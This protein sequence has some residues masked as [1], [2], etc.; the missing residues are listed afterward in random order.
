LMKGYPCWGSP[1][2]CSACFSFQLNL[3]DT[4]PA[5]PDDQRSSCCRRCAREG[6]WSTRTHREGSP[7]SR[8]PC[9]PPPQDLERAA[10]HR[11]GGTWHP[12]A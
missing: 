1:S 8:L 4:S 10:L 6:R 9:P 5:A 12:C 3:N 11:P 2:S 7:R